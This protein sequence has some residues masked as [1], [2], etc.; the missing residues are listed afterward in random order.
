MKSENAPEIIIY[1]R[2]TASP[3][4]R[5]EVAENERC[6]LSN[7]IELGSSL[8]EEMKKRG[9]PDHLNYHRIMCCAF[10]PKEYGKTE[11]DKLIERLRSY[12]EVIDACYNSIITLED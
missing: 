4:R 2:S 9:D 10:I 3:E 5:R 6:R 7:A 1:F 12:G 8:A 11:T